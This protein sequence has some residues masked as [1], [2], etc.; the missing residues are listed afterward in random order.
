[1]GGG[2]PTV[3]E[4][5]SGTLTSSGYNSAHT[6]SFNIIMYKDFVTATFKHLRLLQPENYIRIAAF[7]PDSLKVFFCGETISIRYSTTIKS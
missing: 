4:N 2:K 7:S 1:M 5:M 3:P 6:S